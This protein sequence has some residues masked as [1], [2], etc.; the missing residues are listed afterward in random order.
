M[1]TRIGSPFGF[2]SVHSAC[3]VTNG[4][5]NFLYKRFEVA[6]LPSSAAANAV[7]DKILTFSSSMPKFPSFAI[8]YIP[9]NASDVEGRVWIE[10]PVLLMSRFHPDNEFHALH[11]DLVPLYST[12]QMWNLVRLDS[13]SRP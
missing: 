6:N 10:T 3:Q 12:L 5:F 4:C 9:R 8:R 2:S 1:V 7:S 11:D 13:Q